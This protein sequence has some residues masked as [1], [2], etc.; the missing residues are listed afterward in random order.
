MEENIKD[1]TN[2]IAELKANIRYIVNK[3]NV[4]YLGM[5]ITEEGVTIDGKVSKDITLSI[6]I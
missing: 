6:E 4:K 3:Y 5:D 2:E 1:M